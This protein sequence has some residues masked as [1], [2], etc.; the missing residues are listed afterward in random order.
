MT[1]DLFEMADLY[2]DLY[3]NLEKI[4]KNVNKGNVLFFI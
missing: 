2:S 4:S 1:K 3:Q